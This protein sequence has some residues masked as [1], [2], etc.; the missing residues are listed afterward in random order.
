MGSSKNRDFIGHSQCGENARVRRASMEHRG[1]LL[2]GAFCARSV[3]DS[4]RCYSPDS[5]GNF[6]AVQPVIPADITLTLV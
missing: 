6:I 4:F 5:V 1:Q 3:P 2:R